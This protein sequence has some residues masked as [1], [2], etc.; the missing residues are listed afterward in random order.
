LKTL[1]AG[2]SVSYGRSFVTKRPTLVGML[3]LGYADG[4]WRC[5]SN[6][7]VMK[8]GSTVVPVIGR[9]CMDQILIDVTD[10]PDAHIGQMA[11]V[12]DDRHD[13]PCGVY[14]LADLAQTICYEILTSVHAHVNLIVH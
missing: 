6:C 8:I 10:V 5:F 9:V 11:T 2:H 3:P 13:S 14:A 12:I 1:P 4:Y 7:A